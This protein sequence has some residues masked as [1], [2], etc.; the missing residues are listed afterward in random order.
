MKSNP[1]A[2]IL[3]LACV[4]C[5]HMS[6]PTSTASVSVEIPTILKN[7]A[8]YQDKVVRIRG[9]AVVRFEASYICPELA[10]INSNRTKEC[11]WLAPALAGEGVGPKELARCHKKWVVLTGT[12]DKQNSG[13]MDAYGGGITAIK[14][15]VVGSHD[16]GDVPPPPPEPSAN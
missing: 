14:V 15:E 3:V 11:L 10:Q 5:S 6:R 16:K 13:H 1:V 8:A 2:A 12:F 7:P 9:A 4:G